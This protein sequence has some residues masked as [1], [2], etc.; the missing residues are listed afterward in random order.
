M[1]V[2]FCASNEC[3]MNKSGGR[4]LGPKKPTLCEKQRR[5]D[6]HGK[7]FVAAMKRI[8]IQSTNDNE[9][10]KRHSNTHIELS[11]LA[12]NQSVGGFWGLIRLDFGVCDVWVL[13]CAMVI[14]M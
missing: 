4:V 9:R 10:Q 12:T 5:A 1:F 8:R 2:R 3:P 14:K 11:M 7:P 13:W 6:K